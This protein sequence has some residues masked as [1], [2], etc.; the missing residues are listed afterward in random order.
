MMSNGFKRFLIRCPAD[1]ECLLMNNRVFAA[2]LAS[3]L[4]ARKREQIVNRAKELNINLVNFRAKVATEER[5][6]E[7]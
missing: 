6:A 2:E 5:V 1:L 7:E 4:S 3:N